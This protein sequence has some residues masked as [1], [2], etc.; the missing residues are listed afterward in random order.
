VA[1]GGAAAAP[2]HTAVLSTAPGLDAST[3]GLSLL[4]GVGSSSALLPGGPSFGPAASAG[5]SL[6]LLGAGGGGDEGGPGPGGDL[7]RELAGVGVG[8]LVHSKWMREVKD[9]EA[10]RGGA[11]PPPPPPPHRMLIVQ[12]PGPPR[13]PPPC[14]T[15][16]LHVTRCCLVSW[17]GGAP[18]P[19]W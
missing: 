18:T 15:F 3:W 17:G 1:T 4:E 16:S 2:A 5:G 6:V 7:A 14:H 11:P 9:S 12:A 10:R 13:A 19:P 8:V